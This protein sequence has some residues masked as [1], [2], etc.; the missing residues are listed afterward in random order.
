MRKGPG[1]GVGAWGRLEGG[2]APSGPEVACRSA[3]A[4][5]AHHPRAAKGGCE[6]SPRRAGVRVGGGGSV[7]TR[8]RRPRDAG[9]SR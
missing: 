3:G 7:K 2:L 6:K 1:V 8:V 9:G 5:A 4:E